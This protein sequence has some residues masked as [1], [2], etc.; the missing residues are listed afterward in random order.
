MSQ[1]FST[2]YDLKVL[3]EQ[4]VVGGHIVDEDYPDIGVDTGD[5]TTGG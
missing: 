3:N 1:G 2:M 4:L 5:A